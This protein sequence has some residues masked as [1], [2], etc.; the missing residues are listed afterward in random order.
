[1]TDVSWARRSRS[2]Q[3]FVTPDS[4][5]AEI[6]CG[7]GRI[8]AR[9]HA[10]VASLTCFDISD[11][12]L[13]RAKQAL[14]ACPNVEFALLEDSRLPDSCTARFDFIYSFDVFVHL[15]LHTIWSYF[16]QIANALKPGGKAF[17]STAS[18]T[19]PAGWERFTAQSRYTVGGF[20]FIGEDTVRLFASRVGL[21]LV[22]ESPEGG[23]PSNIYINRDYLVVFEKTVE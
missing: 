20:Y 11:E 13:K 21:R 2:A 17:V 9:V 3:A 1:V 10:L 4:I 14:S 16:Q 19:R 5:V 22:K 15:D 18:L 8:A 7:G 23:D 6:G 12:M